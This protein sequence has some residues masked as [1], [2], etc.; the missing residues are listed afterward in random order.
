MNVVNI[1]NITQKEQQNDFFAK[2]A[3]HLPNP[4]PPNTNVT[5]N[6]IVYYEQVTSQYNEQR[7]LEAFEMIFRDIDML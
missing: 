5:S 1:V 3:E 7:L 4:T 6:R 2:Y